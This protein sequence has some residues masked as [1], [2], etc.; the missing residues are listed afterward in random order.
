MTSS[1][2]S[3]GSS[4]RANIRLPLTRMSAS[5][6]QPQVNDKFPDFTAPTTK[7]EITFSDWASGR[8][9]VLIS[10]PAAFTP[11]CTSEIATLAKRQP[12]FNDRNAGLIALTGD[13][14]ERLNRWTADIEALY[15]VKVRFPHVADAHGTIAKGCGLLQ[16]VPLL[17]GRFC[18]RRTFLIGPDGIIRMIL[19]YPVSVGRSVD[20]ILRVL[21]AL[22][23]AEKLEA[24]TPAD[25]QLGEPMMLLHPESRPDLANPTAREPNYQNKYFCTTFNLREADGSRRRPPRLPPVNTGVVNKLDKQQRELVLTRPR[26]IPDD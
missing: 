20:E 9:M 21:D 23:L 3:F 1:T 13:P 11:V 5:K 22:I 19:D 12:E 4:Q 25:W 18:A 14:L 24:L 7:G 8:W 26:H 16:E 10:H 15:G 17:G 2:F 6:W